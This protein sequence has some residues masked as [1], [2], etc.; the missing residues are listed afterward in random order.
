MTTPIEISVTLK[1]E[2][3]TYTH[4]EI[5]YEQISMS[6]EDPKLQLLVNEAVK[7]FPGTPSDVLIKTK[8][9]W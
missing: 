7:V 9:V 1:D 4:R 8:F 2:E 6:H 3:H 5:V